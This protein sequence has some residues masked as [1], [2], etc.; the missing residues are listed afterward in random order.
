M[1]T[2]E[3]V[4]QYLTYI[5]SSISISMCL[6]LFRTISKY[7]KQTPSL[8]LIYWI[9]ITDTLQSTFT[10]MY[11][12][13]NDTTSSLSLFLMSLMTISNSCSLFFSAGLAY[14]SF[15]TIQMKEKFNA[16]QFCYKC[17]KA[18]VP[19]VIIAE[20][21]YYLLVVAAD[22]ALF[23]KIYNVIVLF[24][25]LVFALLVSTVCYSLQIKAAKELFSEQFLKEMNIKVNKILLYTLAQ[26]LVYGP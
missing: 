17:L 26:A 12:L 13:Y 11:A 10:I 19:F 16:E 9:G 24:I 5:I 7:K 3:P 23:L 8:I 2:I 22:S 18:V 20:I 6:W 4:C 14:L 21:V 15:R 1:P 25:P